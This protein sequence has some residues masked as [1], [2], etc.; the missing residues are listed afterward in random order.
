[1]SVLDVLRPVTFG[2]RVA[3]EEVDQLAN[4]FV[5]TD[6]WYRLLSDAVDIIYGPKG[7]GKSALYSLLVTRETQLFDRKILLVAAENPRGATA[8]KSLATDPP[9]TE[10]EFIA[11]WKLYL[12]CLAAQSLEDIGLAS[13]AAGEL[14]RILEEHGLRR[15]Q[16][17][18]QG[19]L[20]TV[21]EYV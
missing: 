21:V 2:Q 13:D 17:N 7:A 1:M 11:L 16:R 8:F 9:A 19:M 5:E 6:H 4:Y 15:R 3:E 18:L 10:R 12:A 20:R 14:Q